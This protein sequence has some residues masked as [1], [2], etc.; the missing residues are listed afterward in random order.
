MASTSAGWRV[1]A[2]HQR[3]PGGSPFPTED[4][5]VNDQVLISFARAIE[6]GGEP[7]AAELAARAHKILR[8]A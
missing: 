1:N 4:A 2:F 6:H 5:K 7:G 3:L 8:P